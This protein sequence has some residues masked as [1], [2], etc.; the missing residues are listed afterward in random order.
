MPQC[1]TDISTSALLLFYQR[2]RLV[3]SGELARA[4][5]NLI[6]FLTSYETITG[7]RM[8]EYVF[9]FTVLFHCVANQKRTAWRHL[10][11]R[12]RATQRFNWIHLHSSHTHMRIPFVP[13]NRDNW[14]N[15]V[16]VCYRALRSSC[17]YVEQLLY[18][19][20]HFKRLHCR[21]YF[22]FGLINRRVFPVRTSQIITT[23]QWSSQHISRKYSRNFVKIIK[24]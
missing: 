23:S 2:R 9:S 15:V 7:Q 16:S 1:L 13:A 21:N 12:Q 10:I 20:K 3:H 17:R 14:N 5:I 11:R 22:N 8:T 6:H 18:K 19:L 4:R 24:S